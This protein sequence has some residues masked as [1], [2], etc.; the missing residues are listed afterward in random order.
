LIVG[1]KSFDEELETETRL[2]APGADSASGNTSPLVRPLRVCLVKQHTTYDLYTKTGP[3]LKS[4]VSSSNWRAGPLGLW[5][6]FD[7]DFR[8]VY[9]SPDRECQIGKTHWAQYVEGWDIWPEGSL[10]EQADSIDWG[11]YDIVICVDVAIPTR[12]VVKYPETMWCYYFIEAGPSSAGIQRGSPYFGYNVFFNQKPARLAIDNHHPYY[13]KMV[14]ERRAI[15][16]FPYYMM[17][18]TT[19]RNVYGMDA[20]HVRNGIVMTS[21]SHE[22]ISSE[23][24]LL[25]ESLGMINHSGI[26]AANAH[27]DALQSEYCIVH[28]RTRRIAGHAL[29]EAIS[30]GCI[31]LA[32]REL[33][34]GFPDLLYEQLDYSDFA[35]LLRVIGRLQVDED[36]RTRARE[37]QVDCVN[38][39]FYRNP[40]RN[41]ECMHAAFRESRASPRGQA[42]SERRDRVMA[43]A[44]NLGMRA[45]RRAANAVRGVS[46]ADPT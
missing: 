1:L 16:D 29:V 28:P 33:V 17:S 38:N 43:D 4:I 35:G 39:Y 40:K 31:A 14:R 18:D 41:L 9:E 21:H 26:G 45:R 25:L 13:E 44:L 15:L 19:I 10:A 7:C 27:R 5:E 46:R 24:R 6:A 11:R 42:W 30:A 37:H 3:D 20:S 32:P 2:P 22:A 8:I 36:L 34:A 23:E 12:I